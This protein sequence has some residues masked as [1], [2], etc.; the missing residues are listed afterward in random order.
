[1]KKDT[2]NYSEWFGNEIYISKNDNVYCLYPFDQGMKVLIIDEDITSK[3]LKNIINESEELDEN[4]SDV[5]VYWM[6][7]DKQD[8]YYYESVRR[9][10]SEYEES[11]KK[12]FEKYNT[13]GRN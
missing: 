3:K 9:I 8:D 11:P 4:P 6:Y 7:V 5:M 13:K 1:M 10:I 12:F 2:F